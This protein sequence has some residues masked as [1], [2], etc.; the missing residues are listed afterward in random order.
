MECGTEG[1][2]FLIFRQYSGAVRPRREN[3]TSQEPFVPLFSEGQNAG[4]AGGSKPAV[5]LPACAEF[6]NSVSSKLAPLG[7]RLTAGDIRGLAREPLGT[8]SND[9]KAKDKHLRRDR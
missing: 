1:L 6:A 4:L 8:K 7:H 9:R 5:A 2:G 3:M